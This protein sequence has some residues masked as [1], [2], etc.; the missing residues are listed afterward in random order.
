[1]PIDFHEIRFPTAIALESRGGPQRKTDIVTL[2]SGR[3]QRNARWAHSRRRYEAGYGVKSLDALHEVI[4]FFE[5]RRGPLY[6][7]RW[8]DRADFKSCPPQQAPAA[9]DQVIGVGDGVRVQFQLIKT[10]GA[11]HDPYMRTIRKP[12]AGTVRLA[13]AG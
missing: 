7:F 1:M 8:K 3:E 12:V 9:T 11:Q 5:E 10:Y 13:V 2:G 4:V 6:G